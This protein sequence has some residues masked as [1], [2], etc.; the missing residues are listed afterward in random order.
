MNEGEYNFFRPMWRRIAMTVFCGA[1]SVLEW[2]T[3]NVE[4]S[5]IFIAMT[6]YCAWR[7][8]INFEKSRPDQ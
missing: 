1:W 5:L 8:L 4:W 7:Y 6:L 3:G 2:S